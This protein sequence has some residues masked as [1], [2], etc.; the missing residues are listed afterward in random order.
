MDDISIDRLILD[1]PGLTPGEARELAQKVGEGLSTAKAP[2][3]SG[4]FET[5]TVDLNGQAGSRNIP[6]LANAIV[7]SLL[8]QIG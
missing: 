6:R 5:L 2:A 3:P 7:S 4:S 1:I 8:R